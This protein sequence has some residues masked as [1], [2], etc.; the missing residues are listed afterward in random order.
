MPALKQMA[1]RRMPTSSRAF[2]RCGRSKGSARADAALVREL[3]KDRDPADPHPGHSRE[4]DALQG[5]RPL[6]RRRLQGADRRTPTSTSSCRRMHDAE[7]AEGAGR[8]RDDQG[9]HATANKAKGV[10]LVASTR[11]QPAA[12]TPAAAAGL[13]AVGVTPS[14]P[15]S[16]RSSRRGRRSTRSCASRAMATTAAARRCPDG[17]AVRRW[18][19]P[20]AGI[21]AR[22]RPPRLRH[23]G[24]AARPDRTGQRHDVHRSDDPDGTEPDEWI[25]AVGS[26]VRNAF[27][28]R[29]VDDCRRPTSRASARRPPT[30]KTAGRSRSSRR[31][32]RGWWSSIQAGS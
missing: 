16:R 25:A 12:R 8:G 24:A 1:R 29:A 3:M 20:L 26:Y 2:T 13:V 17:T 30:R 6:V 22:R 32:C 27:G 14:R 15:R 31:R 4:R 11:P 18:R 23:Q 21:A 28:N 9:G 10:Q 5:R 19:P 7:H